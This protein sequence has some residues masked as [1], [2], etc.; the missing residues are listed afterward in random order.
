MNRYLTADGEF[1]FFPESRFA[2]SGFEEKGQGLIGVK[3][4]YSNRRVGFF[5]KF[6][7]G[8][9][10]FPTLSFPAVLAQSP[11]TQL[12]APEQVGLVTG[13]PSTWVGLWSS[14]QRQ[15]TWFAWTSATP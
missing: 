14:T 10:Q 8:F 5:G 2:N 1:N 3:S 7:P 15:T 4:G 12:S 6:R 13:W 9:V 11:T